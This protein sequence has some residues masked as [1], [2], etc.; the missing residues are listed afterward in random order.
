M[1]AARQHPVPIRF[2][3][4]KDTFAESGPAEG[5]LAKYGLTAGDIEREALD[6]VGKLS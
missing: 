1:S 2:V 4:L 6:V 5:L 3:A